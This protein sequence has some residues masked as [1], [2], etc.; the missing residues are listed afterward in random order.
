MKRDA[1][2]VIVNSTDILVGDVIYLNPGDIIPV[3]GILLKG[4]S[5]YNN[6]VKIINYRLIS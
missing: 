4:D 1:A 6:L 3:D 2:K 5:N